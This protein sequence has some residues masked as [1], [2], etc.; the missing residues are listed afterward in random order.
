MQF[1][2]TKYRLF[3]QDDYQMKNVNGNKCFIHQPLTCIKTKHF[4]VRVL[5][6]RMAFHL[7]PELP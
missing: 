3:L 5:T 4:L 1:V 2:Y 7:A 6:F